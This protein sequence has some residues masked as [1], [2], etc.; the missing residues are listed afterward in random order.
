MEGKGIAITR[1]IVAVLTVVNFTLV[2]KGMNPI[3]IDEGLITEVVSGILMIVA[4]V[5]NWWK[6]NNVTDEA[7]AGTAVTHKLKNKPLT[8]AEADKYMEAKKQMDS[9]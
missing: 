1:L 6:N 3:D 2:Q 5:W 7:V 8:K 4:I 9:Q